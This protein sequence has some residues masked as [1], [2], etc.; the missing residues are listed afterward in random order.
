[1]SACTGTNAT[2]REQARAV[3][4]SLNRW[5][6]IVNE[7]GMSPAEIDALRAEEAHRKINDATRL[8]LFRRR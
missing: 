6:M 4:C 8:I 3:G 5:V 1:M 2:L 7:I